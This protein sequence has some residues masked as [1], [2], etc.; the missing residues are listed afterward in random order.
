MSRHFGGAN[1]AVALPATWILR[2]RRRRVART[3]P[4]G[5]HG[6]V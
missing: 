1:T 5:G 3:P 6:A 2:L 4:E